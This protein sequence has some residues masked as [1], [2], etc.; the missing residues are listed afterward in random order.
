MIKKLKIKRVMP[1]LLSAVLL[2]ATAAPV[3]AMSAPD[4]PD[5]TVIEG[6]VYD[7]NHNLVGTD[8]IIDASAKPTGSSTTNP[9]DEGITEGK[10]VEDIIKDY[11]GGATSTEKEIGSKC[12][13]GHQEEPQVKTY[14]VEYEWAYDRAGL[15]E[16]AAVLTI[17]SPQTGFPILPTKVTYRENDLV[18][19]NT[20][21]KSGDTVPAYTTQHPME[22]G[23]A[24]Y[25]FVFSGWD[26]SEDFNITEDTTIKGVWTL[27][28]TEQTPQPKTYDVWYTVDFNTIISGMTDETFQSLMDKVYTDDFTK[29]SSREYNENESVTV[30]T[31]H[32]QGLVIDAGDGYEW[33]FSGWRRER[34]VLITGTFIVTKDTELSGFWTLREKEQTPQPTVEEVTYTIN[35]LDNDNGNQL[36]TPTTGTLPKGTEFAWWGAVEYRSS[37]NYLGGIYQFTSSDAGF[38]GEDIELTEDTVINC[39]YQ[40]TSHV[41][42]HYYIKDTT[43]SIRSPYSKFFTGH[44]Y[45]FDPTTVK[46]DSLE[47]DGKTYIYDSTNLDSLESFDVEGNKVIEFYYVE[48]PEEVTPE[49][50]SITVYTLTQYYKIKDTDTELMDKWESIV[51]EGNSWNFP[52]APE[53]ISFEDKVYELVEVTGAELEGDELS[54]DLTRTA[55]YVEKEEPQPE[56]TPEPKEDPKPIESKITPEESNQVANA[57]K[58]DDN[59]NVVLYSTVLV[60]ALGAILVLVYKKRR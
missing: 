7:D 34:V 14:D 56:P 54:E 28:A 39:Y 42:A 27:R 48:K 59:T 2:V 37:L 15:V 35:Y 25:E 49:P 45:K 30:D 47:Y 24:P 1:A 57:P 11:T 52:G 22:A 58:T 60:I 44:G 29:P 3:N 31:T 23:Y 40:L 53:T 13:P 46:H 33:V 4:L 18:I 51:E 26:K 16:N 36:A 55:W 32:Y 43:T 21:Y 19:V 10:T 20:T 6:H 5:N 12:S 41:Q 17:G 9:S 8:D 38:P 50:P